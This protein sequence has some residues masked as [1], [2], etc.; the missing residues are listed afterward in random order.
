MKVKSMSGMLARLVTG[1]ALAAMIAM[2]VAAQAQ[3]RGRES[4]G[5]TSFPQTERDYD[6]VF[7]GRPAV[8][9][10]R[11][12][13]GLFVSKPTNDLA[14][15]SLLAKQI[16]IDIRSE[17]PT[18][19]DL[20]MLLEVEGINIT[21]DY[22]SLYE[23][24]QLSGEVGSFTA[25]SKYQE[26]A[27][28]VSGGTGVQ[29]NGFGGRFGNNQFGNNQFGN[30]NGGNGGSP[31]PNVTVEGS[32]SEGVG[33]QQAPQQ[34]QQ[35]AEGGR[36]AIY[37]RIL[38]FRYFRGTVGELMRRLENTGNIAVW[39][40]NGIVVGGMRRYSVSLLQ[41]QDIIQS[42]VNELQNLGAT[43]VVGS[44][45][46]GQLFYSAPPRTNNEIIEPYLRRISGNLSEVTL[47][48]AL[49]T[50]AMSKSDERGF[51]WSA[52]NFGFGTNVTAQ[53][54]S[55]GGGLGGG[56][57]GGTDGGTGQ[58][59]GLSNGVFTLNTNQF[60]ANLGDVFGIDR[61]LSITGAINFLSRMGDTSVAQNVELRTLSGSPVILR[62]GEDIPYVS[63]VGSNF[64]GGLGGGVAQNT[65]TQ[66]LG[67]GLTLNV[68]PRYDHTSGI[69]TMDIGLKLVD[70]VEFV[71]LDAGDQIGTLTQPRTREQGVNSI[72]RVPAGQTTILG[73]IRR[74][75]ESDQ[76]TG[77]FGLFGIGS[78]SKQHEVFWLFAI[79]RPVVTVYETAD[80]PVAPRSI[81]DTRT[82]VNPYD[83]GSYG[84]PGVR[85]PA[86]PVAADP[87]TTNDGGVPTYYGQGGT[88]PAN[89]MP[90]G[91]TTASPPAPRNV[92]VPGASTSPE[93]NPYIP[94]GAVL[95]DPGAAGPGYQVTTPAPNPAPVG[96]VNT[97]QGSAPV[98]AYPV[99]PPEQTVA[100]VQPSG[101]PVIP[102]AGTMQNG[103]AVP[104]V[105]GQPVTNNSSIQT[106]DPDD[107]I[108][109]PRRSFIRPMDQNEKDD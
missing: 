31:S 1:T 54:D 84:V 57:D 79:V 66:R 42:V 109:T 13:G 7:S 4:R 75:F 64:A 96:R 71:Q 11:V 22:N 39:Y 74:D 93:V 80:S 108:E 91:V 10:I 32:A 44:V 2:P 19:S 98:P 70:L 61:I 51:D 46:A 72:I 9:R 24:A 68:D 35:T 99:S 82:T 86:V 34:V 65:Q 56:E 69:V 41:Q 33:A 63:G 101:S 45:G 83:E 92:V 29:S 73:G 90:A 6:A 106:V 104:V 43:Q 76:K 20:Q 8:Q 55:S 27:N 77:P 58:N 102:D 78:R 107:V 16:E 95:R 26:V 52:L 18:L 53:N 17:I 14:P 62:S 85:G 25:A 49:V 5:P 23:A 48:V 38:P 3:D 12:P 100:G 89:R 81:L 103:A 50:V 87:T 59:T 15:Q 40:Q 37:N 36:P 21:I 60:A 88:T 30:N 105:D 94:E 67:T 97:P 47:Q 28:S